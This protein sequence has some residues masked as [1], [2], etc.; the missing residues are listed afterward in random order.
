M[1]ASGR[2]SLLR[3]APCRLIRSGSGSMP[4][5][6]GRHAAAPGHG[7]PSGWSYRIGEGCCY[8][9]IVGELT[10]AARGGKGLAAAAAAADAA[11]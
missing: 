3:I 7:A 2:R 4:A 11:A 1:G 9:L 10:S 5:S 8:H 6:L